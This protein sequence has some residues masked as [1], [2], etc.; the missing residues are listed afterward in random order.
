MQNKFYGKVL[1]SKIY[2]NLPVMQWKLIQN[3]R[4]NVGKT[5]LILGINILNVHKLGLFG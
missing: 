3:N 1:S 4:F 5:T 2:Y